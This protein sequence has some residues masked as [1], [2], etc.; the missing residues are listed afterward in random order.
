M[1]SHWN[2]SPQIDMLLPLDTLS[3]LWAHYLLLILLAPVSIMENQEIP[4]LSLL[5]DFPAQKRVCICT[6]SILSIFFK[7]TS[8]YFTIYNFIK[9]WTIIMNIL[10]NA[11]LY[12]E[13]PKNLVLPLTQRPVHFFIWMFCYIFT[14]KWYSNVYSRYSSWRQQTIHI[15]TKTS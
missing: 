13:V 2:N 15:P 9:I 14:V 3:W 5:G 12:Q 4:L 11:L 1:L 8:I 7:S 6:C 10:Y